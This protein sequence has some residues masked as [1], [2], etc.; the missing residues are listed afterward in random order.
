MARVED[1]SE[2]DTLSQGLHHTVVDLVIDN[3]ASFSVI[4]GVDAFI[5]TI[6][7][8]TIHVFNLTT[9]T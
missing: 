1:S 9:M 4:N 8:V 2:T 5:V 7:F 3:G 6:I